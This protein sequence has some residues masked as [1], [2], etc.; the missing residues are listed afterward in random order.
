MTDIEFD[1]PEPERLLMAGDWHHNS[2]WGERVYRH[3][4]RGDCK[5]LLQLGDWGYW[6][7]WDPVRSTQDGPCRYTQK[8][9]KVASQHHMPSYWLD[10]NHENHDA[11]TPGQGDEWLRHLPRGHRWNWWGLTW[12]SVGG[13][14][15][16]DAD[17]R[18]PNIDWFP[19][20]VL[21]PEEYEYCMRDGQV[22]VIVAH[23]APDKFNIPGVHGQGKTKNEHGWF[24]ADLIARSEENR[25][26]MGTI[27]DE[28]N[29]KFW[30][31]GHYHERHN[32]LRGDTQVIGLDMDGN[33]MNLN[34]LILTPKDLAA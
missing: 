14:V 7:D 13:G 30:F 6:P 9:R 33:H 4:L 31:H 22:D 19:T 25:A 12:M 24:A 29:P 11:L 18:S 2:M 27:C 20:E 34:T 32:S 5:A 28:K 23:D 1:M 26:L 17:R 3:A 8:M 15:S 10:G 21:S 16:V